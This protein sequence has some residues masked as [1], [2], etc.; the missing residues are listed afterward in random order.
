MINQEIVVK[1]P[2]AIE[3][4]E[5]PL[6]YDVPLP[7]TF[8]EVSRLSFPSL[9]GIHQDGNAT[10]RATAAVLDELN[11]DAY[12]RTEGAHFYRDL[13]FYALT[14]IALLTC[15]EDSVSAAEQEAMQQARKDLA[16]DEK[17]RR[18]TAV[19]QRSV[20]AKKKELLD[21]SPSRKVPPSRAK[22][23]RP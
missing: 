13:W 14:R 16:T 5:A 19:V 10:S 17:L 23:R 15:T 2:S 9:K 12:N 21:S 20:L 11:M 18:L 6:V 4:S 7:P 3:Q 22:S 1:A 8:R